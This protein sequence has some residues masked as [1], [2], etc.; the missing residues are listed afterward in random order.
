MED[1]ATDEQSELFNFDPFDTLIGQEGEEDSG[2]DSEN[3]DGDNFSDLSSEADGEV[4]DVDDA[5]EEPTNFQHVQDMVNKL[6]AIL[7]TLLDYFTQTHVAHPILLS[8][9]RIHSASSSISSPSS[10]PS[11]PYPQ[12]VPLKQ[13]TELRIQGGEPEDEKLSIT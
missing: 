9:M 12:V 10:P 8:S 7:K 1:Q 13:I 2:D 6:D 11:T 3:G 4:A 5:Q